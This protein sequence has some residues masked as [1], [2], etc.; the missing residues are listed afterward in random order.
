M[1]SDKYKNNL[2]QFLWQA[3]DD[4]FV[5]LNFAKICLKNLYVLVV[6]LLQLTLHSVLKITI[7]TLSLLFADY[8][9]QL[10]VYIILMQ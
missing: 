10:A 9:M 2:S 1:S 8:C 4:K 3:F 7:R 6:E 5:L